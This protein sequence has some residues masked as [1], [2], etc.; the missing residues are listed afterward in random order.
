VS[1]AASEFATGSGDSAATTPAAT[2]ETAALQTI[3]VGAGARWFNT[4]HLAF[5]FDVRFHK[6]AA[7]SKEGV[8]TMPATLVTAAAG[9]SLK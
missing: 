9:I 6:A 5:S 1:T 3:N 2:R 4:E 8:S 7:R